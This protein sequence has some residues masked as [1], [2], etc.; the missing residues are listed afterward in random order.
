[1]SRK[2]N[3]NPSLLDEALSIFTNSEG[4]SKVTNLDDQTY[5]VD[6][7]HEDDAP[8]N[9]KTEDIV[10]PEDDDNKTDDTIDSK[11][12]DDNS[13]IPQD[14][15]DR[16]NGNK[17][18]DNNTENDDDNKGGVDNNKIED[19][20]D[21]GDLA[22]AEQVSALFD[23]VIES[24]GFNPEDI[25]EKKRPL[26]VDGLTSYLKEMVNENSVP[27]YADERVQKLDE[28][29]KNGGNFEDF[30]QIQQKAMDLQNI[31]IEDES[32]QK[33]VVRELLKRNGYSDDKIERRIERFEDADMLEEEA[34]DA[35]DRLRELQQKDLEDAE[36][37]QAEYQRQQQEEAQQ[38]F[39]DVSGKINKLT[40]IRGINVPQADRKAL[41]DYIFKTDA[42]GLSQYQKDFNKN[43]TKNLI[44]SA[45]F[46]MKGDALI[47][48][49]QRDGESSA[50]KR[51]RSILRNS[52]KNHSSIDVKDEKQPQAWEIA[53]KFL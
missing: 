50:A 17:P 9:D 52:N 41:Y 20:V 53:S 44:E 39:K 33:A 23:A 21:A 10:K 19:D 18:V 7:D 1:M 48:E 25:E 2:K 46:T 35:L 45:Y 4:A 31:D 40:K 37:E 11:T 32:N 49:A 51:L 34:E 16:M 27:Q 13:D 42:Q 12:D 28:Y 6:D 14:V 38:F 3:E 8:G 26:T 43:L 47:S 29:V 24:F 36:K 5:D 30:Y 22:E 15:L